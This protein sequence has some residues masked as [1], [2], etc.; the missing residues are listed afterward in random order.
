MQTDEVRPQATSV[1]IPQQ[2]SYGTASGVASSCKARTQIERWNDDQV[3]NNPKYTT[4]ARQSDASRSRLGSSV[5]PTSTAP[6]EV[7]A[8]VIGQ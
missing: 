1:S 3:K 7:P 5:Q 2:E 8:T 6:A 4:S